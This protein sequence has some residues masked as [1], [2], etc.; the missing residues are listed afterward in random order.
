MERRK[1]DELK[2]R[3]LIAGSTMCLWFTFGTLVGYGA[4]F[5]AQT[6]AGRLLTLGLY[7]VSIILV[8]SYTA[9]LASDLTIT[10]TQNTINGIADIKNGKVQYSRVGILVS[11]AVEDYYLHAIS[12]GSR[13]YFPVY[14]E[15]DIYACLLNNT[16]DAAI[17]D[18]ATL[19]F[20][21]H[22]IYCNLTLVGADF[23]PSAYGIVMRKGWIYAESFD[24][25]ILGLRESNDL[26]ALKIKWFNG[27]GCSASSSS[28]GTPPFSV[29]TLAGLFLTFGVISVLSLLLYAWFNR[30][31]IKDYLQKLAQQKGWYAQKSAATEACSNPNP[32]EQSQIHPTEKVSSPVVR[33]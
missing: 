3:P 31:T 29:E 33:F 32:Y 10:K 26:D 2:E 1:N 6:A 9:N 27:G 12:G 7:I 19:E 28:G 22:A 25:N 5:N 20:A 24:V 18:T 4:G 13:N 21:T 8:A 16:I 14:S 23:E 11:S 17:D 15:Y 30:P